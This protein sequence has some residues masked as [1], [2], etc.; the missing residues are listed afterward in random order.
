MKARLKEIGDDPR[1]RRRAR[2]ARSVRWRCSSSRPT[3][4]PSARPRRSDLDK[5]DRRQVPEAHRGRDQDAG[6]GRQVDGPSVGRRAGRTGPR[7]ADPHRPHPRAGRALRHAAAEAHRRSGRR[8]PPGWTSTSRRWG[9]HG[10]EARLQADG[11]GRHSGGVGCQ[12]LLASCRQDGPSERCS[13]RASIQT[14]ARRYSD[15]QVYGTTM[16]RRRFTNRALVAIARRK[17]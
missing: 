5:Q 14:E 7:L 15:G 2:G 6:G 1:L 13:A 11:G 8:S 16:W 12:V 9:R 4:R 10:S 3:P 17:C